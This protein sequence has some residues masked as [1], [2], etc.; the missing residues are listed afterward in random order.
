VFAP[1]WYSC[2]QS[3]LFEE[4]EKLERVRTRNRGPKPMTNV[5]A[6]DDQDRFNQDIRRRLTKSGVGQPGRKSKATDYAADVMLEGLEGHFEEPPKAAGPRRDTRGDGIAA[7]LTSEVV[8]LWAR[9]INAWIEL[10]WRV[11][12]AQSPA[13]AA[14]Q[15][16]HFASS[17]LADCRETN[18]RMR[19]RLRGAVAD[20]GSGYAPLRRSTKS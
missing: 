3:R 15:Q 2:V 13:A 1:C 20:T 9:R 18:E 14:A 8:A 4:P 16:F 19:A 11:A 10:G 17:A 7:D 6:L 5:I 12:S